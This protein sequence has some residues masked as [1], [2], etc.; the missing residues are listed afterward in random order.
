MSSAS[1]VMFYM[2]LWMYVAPA[3]FGL[4]MIVGTIGNAL[5]I[6]V[7]L[8]QKAMRTVTNILL[9]NL[10]I[11]DIAFLVITVPFT[12]Y[13]YAAFSWD[14]GDMFCKFVQFFLYVSAYVTVWTLV[15]IS[16]Y[17]YLT[18]VKS[19]SSARYRTKSNIIIC[20][21][22][23]WGTSLTTQ[24]PVFLAHTVRTHGDYSYCG[25]NTSAV[26]PVFI[27]FFVFAYVL[28]LL[29][30]CVL[31]V[32]IMLHLRQ[33]KGTTLDNAHA[34]ERTARACKVIILVVVVF[35]ISWLPLHINSLVAT[36]GTLP[37]GA[38]YE[39]FRILWNGMAYGNSCANPFIYNYASQ[40]FRKAYRE[41]LCCP[42][43]CH[44][45]RRHGEAK[46][47]SELTKMVTVE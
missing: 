4:I 17:R 2:V 18:V 28:P 1:E 11:S 7:I 29:L 42:N 5:V 27:T 8:S 37:K 22:C 47:P 45:A 39:V 44:K 33:S 26:E 35:C 21:L 10:A 3:L 32:P 14:F 13:K 16:A 38:Y 25:M 24:I 23:I 20:C 9:F 36:Y 40:E 12:A 31:Y 41:A 43:I 15:A 6:Y 34:K 46:T 30:I 19:N